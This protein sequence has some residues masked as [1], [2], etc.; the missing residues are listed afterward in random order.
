MGLYIKLIFL[1]IA[2]ILVGLG[3]NAFSPK[4]LQ[5]GCNGKPITRIGA[6][7][8]GVLLIAAGIAFGLVFVLLAVSL[9]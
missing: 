9:K 4:G 3:R 7:V 1:M 6:K 8:I 5:P 2:A